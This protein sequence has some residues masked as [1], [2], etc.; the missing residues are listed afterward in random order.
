MRAIRLSQAD[1]LMGEQR[2]QGAVQLL[3]VVIVKD[4]DDAGLDWSPA[5]MTRLAGYLFPYEASWLRI[6]SRVLPALRYIQREAD[7]ADGDVRAMLASGIEMIRNLKV[8]TPQ[9][10]VDITM[11]ELA[12]DKVSIDAIYRAARLRLQQ[13][14]PEI[15]W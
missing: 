1:F 4:L 11:F 8:F 12:D 15:S 5:G 9:E 2:W 13:E 6:G 7:L 3:G 10:C 14:H